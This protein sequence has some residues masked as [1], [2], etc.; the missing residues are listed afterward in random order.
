M[1]YDVDL[2]QDKCSHCGY[3]PPG[4]ELSG[5]TYNLARIFDLAL[6]GK[7]LTQEEIDNKIER[8]WSIRVLNGKKA[9][10][11]IEML[12][13]AKQRLEDPAWEERFRELEPDNKWGTLEGAQAVITEY[14]Q[15][16]QLYPEATWDIM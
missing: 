12:T 6:T 4:P 10:D 3:A 11:T 9:K 14:L 16:A 13:A 7:P 1:S 15:N 8:P 5:P 2:V